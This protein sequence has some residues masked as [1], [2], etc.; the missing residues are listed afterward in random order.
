MAVCGVQNPVGCIPLL[1]AGIWNCDNHIA[2]IRGDNNFIPIYLRRGD[3][4]PETGVNQVVGNTECRVVAP[5][6][7]RRVCWA[8]AGGKVQARV[9]NLSPF[10]QRLDVGGRVLIPQI[11]RTFDLS[12]RERGAEVR[13]PFTLMRGSVLWVYTHQPAVCCLSVCAGVPRDIDHR[14]AADRAEKAC[15]DVTTNGDVCV[16]NYLA[17]KINVPN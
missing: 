16:G 11:L 5:G 1:C 7:V 3:L 17:I 15:G 4:H 10:D 14:R 8:G 9:V 6:Y 2:D 13:N 12:Q